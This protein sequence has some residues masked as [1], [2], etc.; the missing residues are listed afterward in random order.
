MGSTSGRRGSVRKDKARGTYTVVV[1]IAPVGE[2]A[3]RQVRRRGF[4]TARE[5]QRAL[6]SMLAEL[7]AGTFVAPD[8]TTTLASYV[9]EV[10]LPALRVK[11]L[12]ASTLESYQRNLE[13]HVLPRLGTRPL[14]A[15]ATPELDRLYSQLLS[16]GGMR[17]PLAPIQ[18]FGNCP[19]K[20]SVSS[21]ACCNW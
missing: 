2:V 6:T 11:Q 15:L 17:G 8:P 12:R 4:V 14:A 19:A 9:L 16:V 10:W 13:V 5:A 1:D 3:R 18:I 21:R 7:D 20:G